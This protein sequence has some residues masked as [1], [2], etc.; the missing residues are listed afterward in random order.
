MSHVSFFLELGVCDCTCGLEPDEVSVHAMQQ[1]QGAHTVRSATLVSE[2]VRGRY[3]RS[4][5]HRNGRDCDQTGT[6]DGTHAWRAASLW[7]GTRDSVS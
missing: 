4:E 7:G 3:L 6:V 5:E 1:S 2:D